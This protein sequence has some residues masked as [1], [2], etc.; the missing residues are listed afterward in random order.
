MQVEI[1]SDVV[2]PWCFIG[3]RRF[4]DAL[5]RF[6]HAND[7]EV[8][9]RSFEL[10]PS[11]PFSHG[12]DNAARLAAKYGVSREEAE[13]MLERMTRVADDEGLEFRLDIARSGRTFDAH[14][15]L[16]VAAEHGLQG[17]LKEALLS[18]Y[19]EKGQHIA[20]PDVLTKVAVHV[21]LDEGEVRDVLDGDR[22]A[23]DVRADERE[24]HE[25]GVQGVPFFV[26][27]RRYAVSGAQASDVLL[28]VLERTWADRQPVQIVA[29]DSCDIDGC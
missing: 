22:Y 13:G 25:I 6:A 20:D 3:K 12:V 7:V 8:V 1:W 26:F 23:D 17:E 24:A 2:C 15:L 29:G 21:G 18:A 16:H 9:W 11:A 5:S 14:R 19:Q 10:D 27:D 28:E 4:E